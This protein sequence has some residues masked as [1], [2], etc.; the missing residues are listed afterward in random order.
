LN[1]AVL[2]GPEI[3]RGFRIFGN[4]G[5]VGNT[6]TRNI[7]L[8]EAQTKGAVPFRHLLNSFEAEALSAGASRISITGHAVI[9][10][11]FLSPALAQR[12]GYTMRLIND[13]TVEFFKVLIP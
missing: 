6:Y 9:N 4:K 11:G 8:I 5:L 13:E 3:V 1:Q 7:L 10:Q 12:F 2:R